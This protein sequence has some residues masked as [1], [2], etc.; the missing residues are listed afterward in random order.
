M[1]GH[2]EMIPPAADH[3]AGLARGDRPA[4]D[5]GAAPTEPA[6]A[7]HGMTRTGGGGGGGSRGGGGSGGSGVGG[8]GGGGGF[9]GVAR[10]EGSRRMHASWFATISTSDALIGPFIIRR[11]R[12]GA[13]SD[14]GPGRALAAR[15]AGR[16]S[17][18][19]RRRSAMP[20]P[21]RT[22][23]RWRNDGSSARKVGNGSARSAR[24][25]PSCPTTGTGPTRTSASRSWP[26]SRTPG[27]GRARST[28]TR[29][30]SGG[31]RRPGRAGRPAERR[32]VVAAPGP[33]RDPDQDRRLRRSRRSA[34][35]PRSPG[36]AASSSSS[37][38]SR[39]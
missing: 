17:R 21:H 28:A 15:K 23:A 26:R 12:K 9:R 25:S 29:S 4:G 5:G 31:R 39:A 3:P 10:A 33:V 22:F 30:P 1:V 18:G 2:P 11:R 37:S 19:S 20:M 7:Q 27:S 14:A 36:S 32:Q 38:R 16:D 13:G 35:C 24:C 8:G 34:R 6:A